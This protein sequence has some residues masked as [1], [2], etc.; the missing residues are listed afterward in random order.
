MILLGAILLILGLILGPP[1]LWIAGLIILLV[2]LFVGP[3]GAMLGFSQVGPRRH[4][5]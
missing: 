5:W 3:G 2:G 4:Y 1:I